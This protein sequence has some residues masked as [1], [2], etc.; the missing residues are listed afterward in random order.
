MYQV[1]PNKAISKN[2]NK[3]ATAD[4][5]SGEILNTLHLRCQCKA[6]E[7]ELWFILNQ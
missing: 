4:I 6:M 5:F 2:K 7:E 1:Y 3:K